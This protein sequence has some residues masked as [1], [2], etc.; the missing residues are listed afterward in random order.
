MATVCTA[1]TLNVTEAMNGV[2]E[3]MLEIANLF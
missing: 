2:K 3:S 1:I